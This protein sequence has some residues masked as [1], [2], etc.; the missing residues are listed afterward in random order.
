MQKEYRLNVASRHGCSDASEKP[1]GA[2]GRIEHAAVAADGPGA[3]SVWCR[4]AMA[5]FSSGRVVWDDSSDLP[6]PDFDDRPML[7]VSG[8]ARG[9]IEA[10]EPAVHHF[11]PVVYCDGEGAVIERRYFLIV[12]SNPNAHRV[13][14]THLWHDGSPDRAPRLSPT[15]AEAIRSAGMTGLDW[16]DAANASACRAGLPAGRIR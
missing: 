5:D 16:D 13:G 4:A 2:P 8:R 1:A 14:R 6:I 9:L 7:S 15:L 11:L 12:G 10:I 3:A